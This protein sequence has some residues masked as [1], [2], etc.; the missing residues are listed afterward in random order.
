M[1]TAGHMPARRIK[2]RSFRPVQ[3]GSVIIA[4]KTEGPKLSP[5]RLRPDTRAT[6]HRYAALSQARTASAGDP[7]IAWDRHGTRLSAPGSSDDPA[8]SLKTFGDVWVARFDNPA[9]ESGATTRTRFRMGRGISGTSV[10][11]RG[12][13]RRTSSGYSM[14]RRPLKPIARGKLRRE[15]GNLSWSRFAGAAGV[16][17]I[18]FARSTDHDDNPCSHP[19]RVTEGLQAIQD[20]DIAVTGNGHVL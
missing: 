15:R 1:I 9:G 17:A 5:V 11:A 18:Y 19:L 3:S 10:I 14:T 2:A 20:P 13:S 8:G 4:R 12:S 7:V 6:G 16:N